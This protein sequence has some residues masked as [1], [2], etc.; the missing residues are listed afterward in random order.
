ALLVAVTA[1]PPRLLVV[2]R[3]PPERQFRVDG[4]TARVNTPRRGADSSAECCP[5]TIPVTPRDT[6]NRQFAQG[7][8][9]G[10]PLGRATNEPT[11]QDCYDPVPP[12]S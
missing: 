3:F 4:R 2:V 9:S 5:G 10:T 7:K 12:R 1:A 11:L 8:K 6:Q